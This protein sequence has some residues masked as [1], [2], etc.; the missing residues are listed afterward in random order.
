MK[1]RESAAELP[2]AQIYVDTPLP[3]LDRPFDYLVPREL[4]EQVQRGTR[5]RVRFA[6][7]L[8]DGLVWQ[9]VAASDHK[10]ALSYV[11]KSVSPERV[12]TPSI[13]ALA[14][15]LAERDAG[16]V[17]DV[18]RLAIPPRHAQEENAKNPIPE[19]SDIKSAPD[20]WSSYVHGPAYIRA[21]TE[22]RMP[23]AV[24][25]ALPGEDWPARIG[26]AVTAT[27]VSGRSAI[28]VVP[29]AKD[30]GRLDAALIKALG[31]D[32]HIA[33]TAALGPRERYRRWLRALRGHVHCV[34][35]TRAAAF[36]PV[37]NLGL[38]AIWDDGDDLHAEP[39][40]PYCH[41]RQVLLT[42]AQQSDAAVLVAGLARTP[43]AQLL[44]DTAWAVP[45]TAERAV[46]RA[47][48]PR[49]TALDEDAQ[50]AADAAATK[51]RLPTVAWRA[52][53]AALSDGKPVLVQ[54]PRRGYL[55]SLGC[56]KC[57]A[58]A[59]CPHCSGPLTID[60]NSGVPSCQWCAR[61]AANWAC[62]HCQ[63]RRLRARV[64]GA[65]RTAEEL[66]RAFPEV[67]IRTSSGESM[68][69]EVERKPALIIATP[70]A[71]PHV[72]GGYGAALLLDTW[73]LLTRPE[74]RAGQEALRRWMNACA[75]VRAGGQVVVVADAGL[76][77]VQALVRWD[78]A[79]FA[80]R[81]LAEREELGFPPAVRMARLTG[82]SAALAEL[83][84][85]AEL[86]ESAEVLGPVSS[87]DDERE[88]TE[89]YLIRVPRRDALTLARVLRTS[90]RVRSTRK[91]KDPVRIE[92]DP[93][94][95]G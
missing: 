15:T 93:P 90:V 25:Q 9:R 26:D 75:L 68:L 80:S 24:W 89:Q 51:A 81:E 8:L 39:R 65:G 27:L 82:T 23:R 49:V 22:K 28:V 35:G 87:D 77:I 21:L 67:T 14:T 62:P 41:A 83:L 42:R 64:V 7:Q 12:L 36:A 33:L 74:L 11:A 16:S 69:D 30:L 78:P 94:R 61:P 53:R 44:I 84:E 2:V 76:P 92:I 54:V 19:L 3:H 1:T 45:L 50:L 55:P 5:V 66:G 6:G 17:M 43:E 47:R 59:R 85:L 40:A 31:P 95:L 37:E 73:A 29:D 4:D 60:R 20:G 79:G 70:G 48:A 56:E 72:A 63:G 52:A 57:R 91:A 34:I 86:P 32:K 18:L 10:G 46:V 38:V 13:A 71:E 58:A 88:P